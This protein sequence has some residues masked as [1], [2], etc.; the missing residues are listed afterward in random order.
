MGARG[1][2][3]RRLAARDGGNRRGQRAKTKLAVLGPMAFARDDMISTGPTLA[4]RAPRS[5]L[6]AHEC[7]LYTRSVRKR[8]LDTG[9]H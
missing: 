5:P 1:T 9:P 4:M 2:F 7:I 3:V 6:W 8:L